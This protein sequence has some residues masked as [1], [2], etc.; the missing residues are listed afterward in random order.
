MSLAIEADPREL[1]LRINRNSPMGGLFRGDQS[2]L[3]PDSRLPWRISPEPF[4]LTSEQHDVLLRLGDA[5]LAFF[6]SCNVLYHQSVKGIQPEFIARYLDAGKP[7]RVIDLG[8]LNR[9]KSHLPLVM[10][11]DLILTADGVRAVELDSIPG[12]I[13]FTGQISRIYS[14]IGY[15]VVGGGD[16]LLRGFHDALTTSLP[17]MET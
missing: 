1:C 12:G 9:V 16:G 17:E 2:R 11:P 15:D 4:W 5:L 14:E 13:G 3:H 8:R 6:R 10:R 7:E